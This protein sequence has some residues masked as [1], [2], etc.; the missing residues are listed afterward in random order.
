M[1]KF[2]IDNG[3]LLLGPEKRL[4]SWV[5]DWVSEWRTGSN[6]RFGLKI[7][8]PYTWTYISVR[9]VIV[10]VTKYLNYINKYQR[11]ISL[12]THIRCYMKFCEFGLLDNVQKSHCWEKHPPEWMAGCIRVNAG[13]ANIMRL[14]HINANRRCKY[15]ILL[16]FF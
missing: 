11:V 9:F 3:S 12:K 7:W 15:W 2:R 5:T 1:L 6:R 8:Y 4:H 13:N 14:W 10:R 16:H